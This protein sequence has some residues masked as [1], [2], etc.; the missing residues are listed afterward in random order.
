MT[1]RLQ[2]P[3]ASHKTVADAIDLGLFPRPHR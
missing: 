3:D 1:R 2:G